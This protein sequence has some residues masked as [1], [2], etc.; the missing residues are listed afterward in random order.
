MDRIFFDTNI[1]MDYLDA[2]RERHAFAAI[3]FKDGFLGKVTGCISETVIT[4]CCYLLRKSCSQQELNDIFQGFSEFFELLPCTN[5]DVHDACTNNKV[6]LE[7]TILYEIAFKNGCQF[8]ITNNLKHFSLITKPSLKV[9]TA[10]QY[11]ETRV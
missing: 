5:S 8:F 2:N 1:V 4:N 10:E 3:L 7:D 11:L 6:D 9:L